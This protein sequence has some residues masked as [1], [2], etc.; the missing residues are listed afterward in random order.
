MQDLASRVGGGE[1]QPSCSPKTSLQLQRYEMEV[2]EIQC[3]V[4]RE[5]NNTSKTAFL[6]GMMKLKKR[7]NKC[8][9]QGG[10]YFEEYK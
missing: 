2:E 1:Q 10:M 8:V 4:T 9:Y 3:A 7:A 6:E 5:L